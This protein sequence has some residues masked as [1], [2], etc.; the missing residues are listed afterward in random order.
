MVAGKDYEGSIWIKER[1]FY[2][3][4]VSCLL[5]PYYNFCRLSWSFIGNTLLFNACIYLFQGSNWVE[6]SLETES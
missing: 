6:E 5:Q 2:I 1:I 4:V 3:L